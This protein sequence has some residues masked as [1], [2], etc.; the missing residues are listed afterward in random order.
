MI[1]R[2]TYSEALQ[3][4]GLDKDDARKTALILRAAGRPVTHEGYMLALDI[5]ALA[6]YSD[7]LPA[8]YDAAERELEMEEQARD[9][10]PND[11]FTLPQD[12]HINSSKIAHRAA[13]D[14]NWDALNV[15]PV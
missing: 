12:S 10:N 2:W 11:R 8:A 5:K 4:T 1:Q 15:V 6:Y 3:G 13:Q 14:V 7:H 9:R